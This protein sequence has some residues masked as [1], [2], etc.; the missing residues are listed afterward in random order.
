MAWK[1]KNTVNFSSRGLWKDD[2]FAEKV[3]DVLQAN[4]VGTVH[5]RK[6]VVE[7]VM[8]PGDAEKV[9]AMPLSVNKKFRHTVTME[10]DMDSLASSAVR[11]VLGKVVSA[12][13]LHVHWYGEDAVHGTYDVVNHGK[14]LDNCFEFVRQNNGLDIETECSRE[15]R[16]NHRCQISLS[17]RTLRPS[18]VPG[19][20][21]TLV[22]VMIPV[23]KGVDESGYAK[24]EV[25]SSNVVFD[26]ENQVHVQLGDQSNVYRVDCGNETMELCAGDI[27]HNV[28]LQ[29]HL[30][31]LDCNVSM[32]TVSS[33]M[34]GFESSD[35]ITEAETGLELE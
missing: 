17:G 7:R 2:I 8:S 30:R 32:P 29:S 31:R 22:N 28:K 15:M 16:D 3:A 12:G 24:L 11:E 21:Q 19:S 1:N 13:N 5:L 23:P 33:R 26:S 20:N 14:S 4:D 34:R 35:V 9:A 18:A 27:G 10:R 25:P 6:D